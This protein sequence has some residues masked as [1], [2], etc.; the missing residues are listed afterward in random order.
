VTGDPVY[1]ATWT[2]AFPESWDVW[3]VRAIAIPRNTVEVEAVRGLPSDA[4]DVV[5]LSVL[6]SGP[7]DLAALVVEADAAHTGITIRTSTSSPARTVPAGDHRVAATVGETEVPSAVLQSLSETALSGPPPGAPTD[8]VLERG[9]RAS[10]RT[11]LALW[12]TRVIAADPVKVAIRVTDPLGR[13]TERTETVPGWVPPPPLDLTLV[14]SFVIV[15]RGVA[16]TVASGAPVDATPPYELA[17]RAQQ[18]G[19][20]GGGEWPFPFPWPPRPHRPPWQLFRS[21][22]GSAL[23]PDIPPSGTP[24]PGGGIQFGWHTA[25]AGARMYDVWI[26]LRTPMSATIS[27]IAPDG[28]RISVSLTE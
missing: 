23:L 17:V 27:L 7:P 21:L 18:R 11:P 20:G 12:F 16:V 13:V 24:T 19:G 6:P 14:D 22:N 26:P 8:P 1:T 3:Q 15:G 28:G 9:A 2:G 5:A 4:S 25:D 10:G